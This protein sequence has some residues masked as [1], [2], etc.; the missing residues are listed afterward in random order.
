[1]VGCQVRKHAGSG[2]LYECLANRHC[3]AELHLDNIKF[4]KHPFVSSLYEKG[5]KRT[6]GRVAGL[7]LV[8]LGAVLRALEDVI[9]TRRRLW[10]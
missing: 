5:L 6:K 3:S 8:R 4:C 7:P 10:L 2:G 9:K 1:M